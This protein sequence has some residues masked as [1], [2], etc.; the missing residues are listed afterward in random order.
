MRW[1]YLSAGQHIPEAGLQVLEVVK[2]TAQMST[3]EYRVRYYCCD[4]EE[5]ITH[6][7]IRKRQRQQCKTCGPCN[8]TSKARKKAAAEA[9]RTARGLK[10][11]PFIAGYHGWPPPMA[12]K[13]RGAGS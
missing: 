12:A 3:T 13:K 5:T 1:D 11:A 4:G 9:L 2:R 8:Y 10:A 7:R 6:S